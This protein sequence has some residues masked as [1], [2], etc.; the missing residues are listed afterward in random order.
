[1]DRVIEVQ[2]ELV[3]RAPVTSAAGQAEASAVVGGLLG[4]ADG[5]GSTEVLGWP[6]CWLLR[7]DGVDVVAFSATRDG[8]VAGL[9]VEGVVAEHEGDVAGHALA[10]VDGHGVAVREV[11]GG[12]VVDRDGEAV[13]VAGL[14]VDR[15]GT[16]SCDGAEGAVHDADLAVVSQRQD[17]V[18][19][20]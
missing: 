17:P 12:D 1:M 2:A 15:V 3:L 13:T 9:L 4:G 19:D 18:A 11:P 16:G 6:D 5:E 7:R 10:L 8:R 14:D 20:P